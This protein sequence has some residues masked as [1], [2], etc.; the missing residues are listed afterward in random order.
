MKT[1]LG[2]EKK[3]KEKKKEKKI[4]KKKERRFMMPRKKMHSNV[5][6]R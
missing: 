1:Q 3:I 5:L 6:K 4:N 2:M